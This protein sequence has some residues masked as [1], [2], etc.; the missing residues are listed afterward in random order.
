MMFDA[1]TLR[2]EAIETMPLIVRYW[3]GSGTK[4]ENIINF[5]KAIVSSEVID[6]AIALANKTPWRPE[7]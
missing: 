2:D 7:S 6:D 1:K 4:G 5:L 3:R